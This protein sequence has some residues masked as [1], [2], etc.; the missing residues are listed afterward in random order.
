VAPGARIGFRRLDAEGKPTG[1]ITWAITAGGTMSRPSEDQ[2]FKPADTE[3]KVQGHELARAVVKSATDMLI[4]LL[5]PGREASLVRTKLDEALMW[6]NRGLAINGGP[7]DTMSDEQLLTLLNVMADAGRDAEDPRVALYRAQQVA[8]QPAMGG[9]V[10]PVGDDGRGGLR[11]PEGG[12]VVDE[13]EAS[14]SAAR[15]G[16]PAHAFGPGAVTHSHG[17]HTAHT[18]SADTYATHQP[19]DGE[20]VIPEQ[21]SDQP[22]TATIERNGT[23]VHVSGTPGTSNVSLEAQSY[24]TTVTVDLP[25]DLSEILAASLLKARNASK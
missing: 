17:G 6:G 25:G 5:P 10:A 12:S 20:V 14:I 13:A 3:R 23:R 8:G 7:A 4:A 19:M 9:F 15:E 2:G 16:A 24:D 1:P 21:G 11:L 18:H 22:Y